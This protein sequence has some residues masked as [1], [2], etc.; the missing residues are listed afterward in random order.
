MNALLRLVEPI[1][2]LFAKCWLR[3]PPE[4]V[5]QGCTRC[6]RG[7]KYVRPSPLVL[8]WEAGADKIGDFSWP[9]SDR[10]AVKSERLAEIQQ[11]FAGVSVGPIEMVQDPKLSKPRR[12]TKL[13]KPRVWLPLSEPVLAELVVE[14]EVTALDSSTFANVDNCEICKR[15]L[16]RLMGVEAKEQRWDPDSQ[17]LVPFAKPRI[18][19]QGLFV[20]QEGLV[21]HDLFRIAEFQNGLFCTSRF[22]R[23]LE[24]NEFTN[25]ES[26]E[27]GEIVSG[28]TRTKG[29]PAPRVSFGRG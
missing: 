6:G 24:R 21:G 7:A 22:L 9:S 10:T 16:R 11:N 4:E 8:E 19:G 18:P 3:S 26:L 2:G 13:T 15:P 29:K 27:Y 23:W 1:D 14:H 12:P 5:E 28:K 17:R 20:S 25:V